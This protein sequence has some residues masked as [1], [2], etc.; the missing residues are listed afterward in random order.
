MVTPDVLGLGDIDAADPVTAD[1]KS[2]GRTQVSELG[3]IFIGLFSFGVKS[4]EFFLF[5]KRTVGS[6]EDFLV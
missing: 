5:G 1:D 4:V 2:K 3:E 6:D